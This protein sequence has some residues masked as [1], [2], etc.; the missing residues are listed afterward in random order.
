MSSSLKSP[1]EGLKDLECK[2]GTFPVRPPIPYVPP[3]DLHEKQGIK[4][5]KVKLPVGTHFQ[6]SDFGKGNNKEYLIHIIAVMRLIKQKGTAQDVKKA[7][8]VLVEV[9]RE[10]LPLLKFPDNKTETAKEEHN[11]K[12]FEYKK[13]LK[14]K[15]KFAIAEAQK[16]YKLLHY[17]VI[18]KVQTQWDKIV[19]EMHS[20]DP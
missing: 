1:P 9:R 17:F 7:F 11:R 15:H 4:Q 19:T 14:T 12:L 18:G 16:A 8:E 5:I 13:V 10:L 2:K 3:A 6:M 20:K